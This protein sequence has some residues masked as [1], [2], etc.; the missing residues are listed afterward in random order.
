MSKIRS[1]ENPYSV[2]GTIKL[3]GLYWRPKDI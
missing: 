3:T 2:T 1:Y